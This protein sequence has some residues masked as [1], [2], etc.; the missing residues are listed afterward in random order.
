MNLRQIF[1]L[2]S[3][4]RATSGHMWEAYTAIWGPGNIQIHAAANGHDCTWCPTVAGVSVD[5]LGLCYH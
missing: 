5:A 2:K 4:G 3:W 1:F